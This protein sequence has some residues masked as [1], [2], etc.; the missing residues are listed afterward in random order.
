LTYLAKVSAMTCDG[1]LSTYGKLWRVGKD[2]CETS[3]ASGVL[4]VLLVQF[5]RCLNEALSLMLQQKKEMLAHGLQKSGIIGGRLEEEIVQGL[6]VG[7]L[8]GAF[9]RA[10]RVDLGRFENIH[11]SRK[12]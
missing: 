3:D 1:S 10:Q 8:E 9:S 4:I 5:C 6:D 2:A 7:G 12:S 11:P